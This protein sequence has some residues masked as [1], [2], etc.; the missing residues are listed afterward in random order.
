MEPTTKGQWQRLAPAGAPSHHGQ[1]ASPEEVKLM[2]DHGADATPKIKAVYPIM[3]R[4]RRESRTVKDQVAKRREPFRC[5]LHRHG[6][7]KP[8][9]VVGRET[10][11][12][13]SSS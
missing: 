1:P 7:D 13:S 3:R 11:P 8:I 10:R 4:P 12:S 5:H 6:L 9:A 2:L